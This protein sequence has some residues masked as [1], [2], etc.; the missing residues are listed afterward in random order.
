MNVDTGAF[1]ALTG[2]LDELGR[3][4]AALA[5]TAAFSRAAH[6]AAI[7]EGRRRQAEEFGEDRAFAAGVALGETRRTPVPRPRHARPRRAVPGYLRLVTGQ[8]VI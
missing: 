3:R 5:E 2:R 4:V 8:E 7:A 1:A 6:D